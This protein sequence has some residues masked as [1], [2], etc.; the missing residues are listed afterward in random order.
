MRSVRTWSAAV[1]TAALLLAC[2]PSTGPDPAVETIPPRFAGQDI[3]WGPCPVRGEPVECGTVAVPLDHDRPDGQTLDLALIRLPATGA[4]EERIGSLVI[5]P[6]GPGVPG[7]GLFHGSAF[8]EDVR[9]AFDLVSF[10]P[11]GVGASDVLSC[12]DLYALDDA[13]QDIADVHPDHLTPVHLQ[14]LD[15]AARRYAASCA[16]AAG[17]TF[18]AE[19][20]TVNVVRD[21]E[22]VRDALGDGTLTYVGYSYGAHIGA[23]YA[24]TYPSNTRAMVLDAAVDTD[25]STVEIAL[26]QAVAFQGA[27]ER[28]V[29]HCAATVE[30][31][32]F[33]GE[34]DPDAL[35]RELLDALDRDPA[36][37]DG[38]PV[39]GRLLLLMATSALYREETWD[40]LAD[41][42]AALEREEEGEP[43]KGLRALYE[44]LFGGHVEQEGEEP[45]EPGPGGDHG[46][47]RAAYTAVT[48]ADHASPAGIEGYRDVAAEAADRS[49]LFGADAVWEHLPCAHWGHAERPPTGFTAPD[50]PPVVIIGTVGDPVTPYAWSRDLA[51]RLD[52]AVLITYEGG[53][54]TL[55]GSGR[56]PCVEEPVDHYLLTGEPPPDG[57]RCPRV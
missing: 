40:P 30:D 13:R 28:F 57:S 4:P 47:P 41:A 35:A 56:V 12:G 21:L 18:L 5:N 15:D 54:H 8:S 44:E 43:E 23:L 34:T 38:V 49:P 36:S 42:F 52:H 1:V 3:A 2:P 11:R 6:G 27:W 16:E 50:A 31:C 33:A 51:D 9:S 10:D 26:D 39:D 46:D 17:E 22:I 37:V 25:G 29:A 55:Y 48:C 7:T 14:P 45:V 32:P 24:H 20:G 53:G 19:I